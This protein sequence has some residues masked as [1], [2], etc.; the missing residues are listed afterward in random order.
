M[1]RLSTLLETPDR[2]HSVSTKLVGIPSQLIVSCLVSELN[3]ASSESEVQLC[4][5][6]NRE[7][8]GTTSTTDHLDHDA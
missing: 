1:I 5:V 4:F 8:F 3:M 6:P 2:G 7:A